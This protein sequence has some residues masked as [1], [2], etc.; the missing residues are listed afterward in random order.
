[1]KWDL[2]QLHI[3]CA[4]ERALDHDRHL[5]N[6]AACV[7]VNFKAQGNLLPTRKRDLRP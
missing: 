4:V 6:K 2:Y 3:D 7:P 1:M 5:K